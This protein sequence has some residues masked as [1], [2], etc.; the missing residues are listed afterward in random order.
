MRPDHHIALARPLRLAA[1][2][3]VVAVA[4]LALVPLAMAQ[5]PGTRE[6]QIRVA[7]VYKIARFVTWPDSALDARGAFTFCHAGDSATAQ[8]FAGIE[9]RSTQ[10]HR[11]RVRRL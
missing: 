10:G 11:T 8:V 7:L 4:A 9:G 1:R 2:A 5:A 3:A 6:R